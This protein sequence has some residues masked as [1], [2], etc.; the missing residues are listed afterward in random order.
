M[1]TGRAYVLGIGAVSGVGW[2]V[3][4]LLA[5]PLRPGMFLAGALALL[6]QGP[7]GWWLVRALGTPR[8]LVVWGVG[9]AARVS[10]VGLAAFVLLPI[11]N[12][13]AGALLFPLAALL[14][15]YLVVEGAVLV[16]VPPSSASRRI[17]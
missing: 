16:V 4:A 17:A 11:L 3:G 10:L 12:W 8:F 9:M 13:S 14:L 5:P 15:A 2:L 1:T 7:L 6:V